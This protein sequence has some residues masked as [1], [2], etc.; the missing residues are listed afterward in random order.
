MEQQN[1]EGLESLYSK[2]KSIRNVTIDINSDSSSQNRLLD[3]TGDR[4]DSLR[5]QIDNSSNRFKRS[6]QNY[7][8]Q[9]KVVIYTVLTVIGIFFLF[10]LLFR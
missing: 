4:L 1:D 5:S 8:S 2:I 10:K 7:R 3:Q 6:I 9:N